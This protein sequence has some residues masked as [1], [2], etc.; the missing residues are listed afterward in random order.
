[1]TTDQ[2]GNISNECKYFLSFRLL[3]LGVDITHYWVRTYSIICEE[4]AT[5]S[6][7][8][9]TITPL[10]LTLNKGKVTFAFQ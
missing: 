5:F 2:I 7:N 4:P 1:M 6:A 10:F 9:F 3:H 8:N